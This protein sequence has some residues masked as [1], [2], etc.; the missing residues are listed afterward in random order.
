MG[1]ATTGPPARDGAGG[2]RF[3]GY[4]WSI[5]LVSGLRGS[6]AATVV[7]SVSVRRHRPGR[8]DR[9]LAERGHAV[10]GRPALRYAGAVAGPGSVMAASAGDGAVPARPEDRDVARHPYASD[11]LQ[12]CAAEVAGVLSATRHRRVELVACRPGTDG[13]DERTR[14]RH[15]PLSLGH[16]PDSRACTT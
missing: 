7:T 5:A 4:G 9:W 3:R 13:P 14:A 1:L 8:P 15:L 2:D 10:R 16:T 11:L 6:T 12:Q